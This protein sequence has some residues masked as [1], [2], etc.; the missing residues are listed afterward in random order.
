MSVLQRFFDIRHVF[1]YFHIGCFWGIVPLLLTRFEGMHC[2]SWLRDKAIKGYKLKDFAKCFQKGLLF[3]PHFFLFRAVKTSLSA[4][5]QLFRLPF[6][7][8]LSILSLL[9]NRAL[10]SRIKPHSCAYAYVN[11][12]AMFSS[13][14]AVVVVAVRLQTDTFR[15][16]LWLF[17]FLHKEWRR[18]GERGS[19]NSAFS[20]ISKTWN[21]ERTLRGFMLGGLSLLSMWIRSR[22]ES[23]SFLRSPCDLCEGAD[24]A[25]ARWGITPFLQYYRGLA[26]KRLGLVLSC[27][28]RTKLCITC[29]VWSSTVL[30][31]FNRA[32]FSRIAEAHVWSDTK[33]QPF[34][35]WK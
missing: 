15:G 18:A 22:L 5:A 23:Q 30:Q 31:S 33:K 7:P 24:I 11:V 35:F 13:V 19:C 12:R 8:M 2:M 25:A 21:R 9:S 28:I 10:T 34:S 29:S 6:R 3:A 4:M 16:L 14:C 27:R 20:V 1:G 32:V 26:Q 17:N